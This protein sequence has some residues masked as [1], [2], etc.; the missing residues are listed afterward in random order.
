MDNEK[1]SMYEPGVILGGC[2]LRRQLND[3]GE[4]M[5]FLA[6]SGNEEKKEVNK[7]IIL[8]I[9]SLQKISA[10][11]SKFVTFARVRKLNLVSFGRRL[12]KKK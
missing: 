5:V 2:T 12:L 10:A 8:F 3:S 6:E 7:Y 1:K 11:I 9:F 4:A